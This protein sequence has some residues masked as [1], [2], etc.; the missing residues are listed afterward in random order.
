MLDYAL[1]QWTR[2]MA[3]EDSG[4]LY[5]LRQYECNK[6]KLTSVPEFTCIRVKVGRGHCAIGWFKRHLDAHCP[7]EN[8]RR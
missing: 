5:S 4:A 1:D 3:I 8:D 6:R 7:T 2:F